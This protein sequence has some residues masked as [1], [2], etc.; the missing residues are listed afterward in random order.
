LSLM[1]NNALYHQKEEEGT[2]VN[3]MSLE[4]LFLYGIDYFHESLEDRAEMGAKTA[5]WTNRVIRSGII[6]LVLI[7]ASILVLVFVV[8]V[9]VS[10]IAQVTTKM[11]QHMEL[12]LNDI[13]EMS[14]Y[15]NAI[16]TNV[17]ALPVIVDEI[18]IMERNVAG[19]GEHM[20]TISGTLG[21]TKY[22]VETIIQDVGEMEHNLENV[23]Y[24]VQGMDH[25]IERVSRP[26]R[27]FNKMVPMP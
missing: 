22:V 4:E 7:A 15:V 5:L 2:S 20:T 18:T 8:S 26:F 9:Q 11:D 6:G 19:M 13:G 21:N 10:Q 3:E 14:D 25:S 12:M 24:I 17:A 16:G 27:L 1:N 23:S